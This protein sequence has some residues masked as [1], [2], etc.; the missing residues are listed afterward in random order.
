MKS[1]LINA[2]TEAL[3]LLKRRDDD[4]YTSE[5]EEALEKVAELIDSTDFE[6]EE[7]DEYE[8]DEDGDDDEEF[9]DEDYDG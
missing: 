3:K 8:D 6:C 4:D 2:L 1:E 9:D 5:E 7:A